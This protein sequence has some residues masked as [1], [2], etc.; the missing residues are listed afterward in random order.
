MA[1]LYRYIVQLLYTELS[2][3]CDLP[4]CASDLKEATSIEHRAVQLAPNC[5]SISAR[6]IDLE[7]SFHHHFKRMN[8]RAD[9]RTAISTFTN[10]KSAT[11]FG[12]PSACLYAAQRWTE[13]STIHDHPYTLKA[14]GIAIDLLSEITGMDR[15]IEQR[16]AS[17]TEISSLTT[18]AASA[19]FSLGKFEK[20]L[21]WL[22]QGRCLVWSQLN[23]LRT[24]LDQLRVHDA[25]LAQRFSDIS[26][27]LEASSSRRSEGLSIDAPLS[28]KI[29][30]HEG[31]HLHIKLSREWSELLDKIRCI[32]DLHNFLRPPHASYLLK[33]LPPDGIVVLI[34]VH[35]SR[36]DALALISGSDTPINIPLDFTQD[37]AS[38]LKG[39]L[40]KL[41]FYHNVRIREADRAGR[42]VRLPDV[43]KHSE[44]HFI[45]ETLWVRVVRPILD[46]LQFS[47]SVFLFIPHCFI[48]IFSKSTPPPDLARIWWCPTGPLTFLPLHAAGM[49]NRNGQSP[50]GSCIA[51]FAISS[52]TPI[53]SLLLQKLQV[54]DSRQQPES[55]KL[56]IISQ[57]NTPGQSPIPATTKEMECIWKATGADEGE[58]LCLEHGLIGKPEAASVERV[59]CE[60]EVYGSIH[61]ACHASQD[62]HNPLKSGFFLHDGR[63][64]LSEIMKQKFAVRELAFLSACQTSAGTE[65][66]SEEAVHLAAGM[67]AAG[68]RSVVATMWSI[69]D[70]YGPI[71]AESFYKYLMERGKTSGQAHFDSSDAARA[72]HHAIQSIQQTIGDSEQGLLTWVPYVHFGY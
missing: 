7:N 46:K 23:Q 55:S 29:S 37:K 71:V 11:T 50:L 47:V 17:L 19:V 30:L 56:L 60:M 49:Y 13:L 42:T 14:Y 43:E 4:M 21:E 63:L 27:A 5:P 72:L 34:N 35:E 3:R 65:K 26:S 38:E 39:R 57:P 54:S 24:P 68:Y 69:K 33:H 62:Q 18:S 40:C 66:L 8:G 31:A 59:K 2:I 51:D 12:P 64:E 25:H 9:I 61:L 15:T 10:K 52:Y 53:V 45:L 22:E 48:N 41:L 16:H 1:P 36:C 70:K 28:Q 20:A 58:S 44:I 32:P 6:P 67:L